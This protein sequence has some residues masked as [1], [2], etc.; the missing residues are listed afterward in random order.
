M[1][2]WIDPFAGKRLVG[3]HQTLTTSL[4]MENDPSKWI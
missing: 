2:I 3:T 4:E 1:E